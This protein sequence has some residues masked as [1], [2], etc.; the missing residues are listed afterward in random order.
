[1]GKMEF[2][3]GPPEH[4]KPE[5]RIH[6][7]LEDGDLELPKLHGKAGV[8]GSE[9]DPYIIV[10]FDTEF[11]TPGYAVTANEVRAGE[12]VSEIL[13]Y[14]FYAKCSDGRTWRGICCPDANQRLSLPQF[15][16]FVLGLGAR[17]ANHKAL[18]T[19]S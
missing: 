4:A 15:M 18:P 8:R 1:M 7:W 10:G 16:L 19:W 5:D 2:W 6:L 13:S 3:I 9:S 11:K 14:Q 17:L 12:A